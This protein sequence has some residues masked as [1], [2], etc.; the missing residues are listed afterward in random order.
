MAYL[1]VK[2]EYFEE[3][4]KKMKTDN[5]YPLV[6]WGS[7]NL[8][9]MKLSRGDHGSVMVLM[10]DSV[11]WQGVCDDGFEMPEAT[12]ICKMLASMVRLHTG[13]AHTMALWGLALIALI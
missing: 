10:S 13:M 8:N 1:K 11:V 2:N 3:K 6:S 5:K 4:I 9:Q 7:N 12:V